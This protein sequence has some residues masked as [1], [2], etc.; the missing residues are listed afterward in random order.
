MSRLRHTELGATLARH[1]EDGEYSVVAS[2]A[3]AEIGTASTGCDRSVGRSVGRSVDRSLEQPCARHVSLEVLAWSAIAAHRSGDL[4]LALQRAKCALDV[5]D[6]DETSVLLHVIAANVHAARGERMN[7]L[8]ELEAATALRPGWSVLEHSVR[9]CG[10]AELTAPLRAEVTELFDRYSKGFDAH[11]VDTLGYRGPEVLA[12]VVDT[13]VDA[14]V[15]R[16][17]DLGC[18]TGLCGA[19]L[20][21]RVGHLTGV[22][23]S[24]C[25]IRRAAARGDYDV[26]FTD[27]LVHAL[28]LT[29]TGAV[30]LI[31]SADALG[32]LGPL[33]AVFE[34][35]ARVLPPGGVIVFTVEAARTTV[36]DFELQ[37][38][39]RCAYS[40]RYLRE[41]MTAAGIALEFVQQRSL[42]R[43]GSD[44]TVC[45]VVGGLRESDG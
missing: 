20:R 22:D 45:H 18:G 12:E 33:E 31:V 8:S 23:L 30:D 39:R 24:P 32:Y 19:A 6:N 26:V 44:E 13:L 14:P 43:E 2:L 35:S 17:L 36:T 7:A 27:D 38:T 37:S 21:S 25:M 5:A 11:L 10:G 28:A 34:E 29:R 1:V 16:A 15:R 40:L 3:E 41:T 42:R 4:D 9:F